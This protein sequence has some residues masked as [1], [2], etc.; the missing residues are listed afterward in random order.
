MSY[1]DNC[2]IHGV[3]F[4]NGMSGNCNEECSQFQSGGCEVGEEILAQ[5]FEEMAEEVREEMLKEYYVDVE[6]FVL[7]GKGDLSD[8]ELLKRVLIDEYGYD[9]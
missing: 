7:R 9:L 6:L 3:C 4:D 2:S 5:W 8:E 1:D